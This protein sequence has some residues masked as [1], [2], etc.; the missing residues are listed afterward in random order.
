MTTFRL[1]QDDQPPYV[2]PNMKGHFKEAGWMELLEGMNEVTRIN[3]NGLLFAMPR[4]INDMVNTEQ[5]FRFY[6]DIG[7]EGTARQII[8]FNEVLLIAPTSVPKNFSLDGGKHFKST[9]VREVLMIFCADMIS[10]GLA[11]L[12]TTRG[13]DR[14]FIEFSCLF[15]SCYGRIITAK[16]DRQ[17]LDN[18][19]R[20]DAVLQQPAVAEKVVPLAPRPQYGGKRLPVGATWD[21]MG[22]TQPEISTLVFSETAAD[23]MRSVWEDK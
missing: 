17:L 9:M 1:Y 7:F 12:F 19:L 3:L 2:R 5:L 22:A 18:Y 13:Q 4:V 10:Y 21:E 15:S 11:D 6:F 16:Q 20:H 23:Y 14:S 8:I